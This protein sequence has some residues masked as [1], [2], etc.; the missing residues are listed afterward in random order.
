M[1]FDPGSRLTFPGTLDKIGEVIPHNQVRYYVCYHPDPDIAAA[2]P[3]I[4]EL[5]DRGD[6]AL[7]T[8]SRAQDLLKHYG[9][10]MPFWLVDEHGWRLPLDDR[11]IQFLF[12]PY[13]HFPGAFCTF[14]PQSGAL[15]SSDLLGGFTTQPTLVALDESHFEGIRFF[16]Q[17]CMP[18][19]NILGYALSRIDRFPFQAIAPQHGSIIPTRLVQFM[20]EKLRHLECGIYLFARGNTDMQR[21][22]RLNETLREI[23]QTM[24]LYSP[25][26]SSPPATGT[27]PPRRPSTSAPPPNTPEV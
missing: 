25:F 10:R 8:H 14:D 24:L 23:T 3:L 26:A 2:M 16:H 6:A 7:V 9:L 13:A 21:L 19:R 27:W 18:S 1:L 11:E 5:I 12:T 15:F 22:S 17:H 20:V 4:D